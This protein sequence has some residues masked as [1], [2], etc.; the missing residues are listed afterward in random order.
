MTRARNKGRSLL[1]LAPGEL[2]LVA[3]ASDWL[4]LGPTDFIQTINTLS[5]P[6]IASIGGNRLIIDAASLTGAECEWPAEWLRLVV[7]ASPFFH[8]VKWLEW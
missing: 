4:S 6:I 7:E 8:Y 3:A 1:Q 5:A 2:Q